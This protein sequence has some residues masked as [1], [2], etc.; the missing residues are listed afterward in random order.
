MARARI[1]DAAEAVFADLGYAGASLRMIGGAIGMGNAALLH[2]FPDK[3]RLYAAV[4]QRIAVELE[5]ALLQPPHEADLR[6]I[7]EAWLDW[8]LARP[9]AA[10]LLLRELLDNAPR[11]ETARSWPMQPLMQRVAAAAAV[12]ARGP[13][14]RQDPMI[15]ACQVI[16]AIAYVCAG[17]RTLAAIMETE[18]RAVVDR[19]RTALRVQVDSLTGA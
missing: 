9:Q 8:N 7:A 1:L 13:A 16:G 11:A 15:L 2:H 5:A 12:S 10:T 4:L 14:A 3:R 19:L 18:P 6:R 17:Q